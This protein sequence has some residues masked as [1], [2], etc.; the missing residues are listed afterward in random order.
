MAVTYD[1]HAI[2]FGLGGLDLRRSVD[3]VDS[4][5]AT[6]LTNAI[7]LPD[8]GWTS[9][10]GQTAL[11]TSASSPLHS[12]VRGIDP[13]SGTTRF[14][15][16]SGTVLYG[17][18]SG[19]VSSL[20]TGYSGNPL[21]LVPWE[22]Q[23]SGQ[24]WVIVGDSSQ[25]KKVRVSDGLVLPIGLPEPSAAPT[26]ALATANTKTIEDFESGF[27]GYAGSGAAPTLS[28]PAGK[29]SNCLNVLTATGAATGAYYNFADKAL[30]LDLST[31]GSVAASDDDYIHLWLRVDNPSSVNEVR[32]YFT[33]TSFTAGTVPGTSTSLNQNGYYKSF[34]PSDTTTILTGT[35]AVSVAPIIV[36][37]R[38]GD[39]GV[40]TPLTQDENTGNFPDPTTTT[41]SGNATNNA[42]STQQSPGANVWTEW[43]S[44]GIPLRRG[45]FQ[46]IG[47]SPTW[48]SI[49]GITV[50]IITAVGVAANVQFDQCYLT[51]G[52]GPDTG[53]PGTQKYDYV[54]SNFDPRT[55][56]EGNASESHLQ[57][58]TAW[59]DALRRGITIT[60]PSGADSAWRQR[61]YRRGG[62]LNDNWRYV[63]VN[64]SNGGAFTDTL[65]DTEI[66]TETLAPTDYF[67]AVPSVTSAGVASLAKAVPYVWGPLQG[68]IFAAGDPN[69]PGAV[70]YPYPDSVDQ[71]S[72]NGYAEV[73][74]STEAIQGGFILG[75]LAFAWGTQRL[76]ALSIN[77]NDSASVVSAVTNCTRAPV[78]PWAH[79]TGES[80][81]WFVAYDGVY[82]T[83]GGP[84][85]NI[86]D[87]WI[88]PL[89]QGQTV[90]GLYPIDLTA[91]TKIRLA[92]YQNELHVFY[93]DT[94][95]GAQSLVYHLTDHVWR[96]AH[97]ANT[98]TCPY[99]DVT[100]GV[101]RLLM[102]TS[103]GAGLIYSGTSDT[104]T[105]ISTT[106]TTGAHNEGYPKC[107]KRYSDFTLDANCRGISVTT[108]AL[109]DYN[110]TTSV[111]QTATGTG[112]QPYITSF[113]PEP[114]LS[115]TLGTTTAWS[116]ALTPPI[117]Y[118]VIPTFE[119]EPPTITRWSSLPTDHGIVGWQMA[120]GMF[121]TLRS[122]AAVDL[123][124]LAH[125]QNGTLL[126]TS[127]YTMAST[128]F[129][130]YKNWI[131]F[132][133][134]KG[135]MYSYQLSSTQPFVLYS[136]ESTVT[137]Q[138]WG[139]PETA[140][141]HL[142]AI[143]REG[144]VAFDAMTSRAA[145]TAGGG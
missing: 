86:S 112:R 11:I 14:L 100:T 115:L 107:Y 54:C 1:K 87:N 109:L 64:T 19:A 77:L 32:V 60:P 105:A 6:V 123:T 73:A 133:A 65:S 78:A 135:A 17:G 53:E 80:A 98:V 20:S 144:T 74:S 24:A 90:N 27:S 138:A 8:G 67:A 41:T 108:T 121:L 142:I 4:L 111:V 39:D 92:I 81:N 124:V 139:T 28:Y 22:S 136:E 3:L 84:E 113:T 131:P 56:A 46:P 18:A 94:N 26:T 37:R 97:Y 47:E 93:Q 29:N 52:A 59:L 33:S 120:T 30:N 130:K 69:R 129:A 145:T 117:I 125:G 63:G 48:S 126:N 10:F 57:A 140:S 42:D 58:D 66:L 35:P 118:G 85:T 137:A 34:R 61:I 72:A 101:G 12:I 102:G 51:G 82:A 76:Y 23:Q 134:T 99:A 68:L 45:D 25:M 127:S 9:R 7:R 116:T 110:V 13:Q 62:T 5:N 21:S 104:G 79:V 75:S 50:Y 16:G 71:W 122:N 88:R 55:G 103:A 89:F 40:K 95:G 96:H 128:G 141:V 31:Y 2:R 15:W 43:G 143:S 36:N 91:T 114:V 49:K 132:N 38:I 106:I 44:V 83:S 119:V 70:Y